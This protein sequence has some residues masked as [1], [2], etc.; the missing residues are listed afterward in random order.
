[1]KISGCTQNDVDFTFELSI[2]LALAKDFSQRK[3]GHSY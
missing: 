1:M 3:I 2:L